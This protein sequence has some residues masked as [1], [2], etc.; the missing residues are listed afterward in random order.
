MLVVVTVLDNPNKDLKSSFC[1]FVVCLA[2][3][4]LLIGLEV[5][6]LSVASSIAVTA[7]QLESL[8]T[9]VVVIR[10]RFLVFVLGCSGTKSDPF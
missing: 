8:L 1:Y 3:C 2:I 9:R 10:T 4:D 7:I 6:P 5:D